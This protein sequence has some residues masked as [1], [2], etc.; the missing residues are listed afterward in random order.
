M[1]PSSKTND[2]RQ[3]FVSCRELNDSKNSLINVK[4]Y[5]LLGIIDLIK[6]D[7]WE[8]IKGKP[9]WVNTSFKE[10][11][12]KNSK[13]HTSFSF[14]TSAL[15]DLLNFSKNLIDDKN[16]QI[17]CNNGEKKIS[18]LNFK[19]AVFWDEQKAQTNKVTLSDKWRTNKFFASGYRKK[20]L[21][22]QKNNRGKRQATGRNKKKFTGS[23]TQLP[24]INKRKQTTKR[25]YSFN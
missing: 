24:K 4:F 5:N 10:V 16:Q 12:E 7:S 11:K 17:C 2:T 25:I 14:T 22:I 13:D 9:L 6:L 18:I 21:R 1:L 20:H 15:K 3:I 19:V 8:N 23:R